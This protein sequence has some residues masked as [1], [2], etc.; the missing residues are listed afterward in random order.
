MAKAKAKKTT[1]PATRGAAKKK[2]TTPAKAT[3]G[4]LDPEALAGAMR[5]LTAIRRLFP[6][7][8][9]ATAAALL[10]SHD[11]DTCR[12][13]GTATRSADTFRGAMMWARTFG[14]NSEDPAVES[15]AIR[16][17]WFL[18]C[19][20]ALGSAIAG[21]AVSDDPVA[22]GRY[23]DLATDAERL[24][25]RSARRARDAAG[26][27]RTRLDAIDAAMAYDG[28]GDPLVARLR[29]LARL[30][31]DWRTSSAPDAPL[32]A[33]YGV[34]AQTVY[35]MRDAAQALEDAFANR[36]APRQ[37]DRDTPGINTAEGRL[38]FVMRSLWDDLADARDDGTTSL[39]LAVSPAIM[40]GL[41]LNARRRKGAPESPAPP[42]PTG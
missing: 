39:Q 27:L 14:E 3:D 34:T 5:Q 4:K 13:K 23:Q 35:R 28:A 32:L 21:N 12:E 18:D 29:K 7:L 9:D 38:Y 6:V 42:A 22:E 19:L 24:L 8:D 33:A 26:T 41:D 17:R 25:A 2:S 36:P 40:R 20:N 11:A 16:V 37:V 31:D 1:R 10:A 15:A 30:I